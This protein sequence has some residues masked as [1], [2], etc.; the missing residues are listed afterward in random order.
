[1]FSSSATRLTPEELAEFTERY[2]ELIKSYWRP[3]EECPP[4]AEPVAVLFYA[5]PWPG[6]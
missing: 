2:V 5:F 6:E 1:M 3:P 4:D